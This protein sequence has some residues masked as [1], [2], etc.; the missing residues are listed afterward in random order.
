M[1]EVQWVTTRATMKSATNV[2]RMRRE[3]EAQSGA[4]ATVCR[5]FP[6]EAMLVL[7]EDRCRAGFKT[8]LDDYQLRQLR[9]SD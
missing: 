4:L 8:S 9:D 3:W 2:T 5:F 1:G 7:A 6:A